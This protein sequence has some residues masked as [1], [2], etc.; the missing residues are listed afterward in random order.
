MTLR[1]RALGEEEAHK[2]AR[3]CC[4]ERGSVPG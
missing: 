2:L 3:I 4:I 1:V